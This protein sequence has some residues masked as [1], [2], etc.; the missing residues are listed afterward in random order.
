MFNAGYNNLG[1]YST[2]TS[3]NGLFAGLKG[4]INF[5][6]ILNNTQKTLN[7]INQAIPVYYQVK[8]LWNNTKTIFRIINSVKKDDQITTSPINKINSS[9]APLKQNNS[10][11]TFYNNENSPRFFL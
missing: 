1:P 3:K 9:D 8:P 10:T 11:D 4:K 6:A 7:I 2:L 5:T